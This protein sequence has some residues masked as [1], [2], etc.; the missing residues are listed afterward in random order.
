MKLLKNR[1]EGDTYLI[2]TKRDGRR[3]KFN[4][5]KIVSAIEAAFN[6]VDGE[7]TSESKRKAKEIADYVESLNKTMTVEQIQD[8]IEEKLMAS[9]R[10]DVAKAYILYRNER[11]FIR[12]NTFYKWYKTNIVDKRSEENS[13]ANVDENNF[14]GKEMRISDDILEHNVDIIIKEILGKKTFEDTTK[15]I[16]IHDKSKFTLGVHNCLLIPYRDMIY[17]NGIETRQGDTK[18]TKTYNTACHLIPVAIQS[19]SLDQ[20]GGCGLMNFS[21]YM[22]DALKNTISKFVSELINDRDMDIY[23][24][25]SGISFKQAKDILGN[26]LYKKVRNKVDKDVEN[27]NQALI[28]NLVTLQ[29][30]SGHQLPF[31][32]INLGLI[33]P[34]NE[35]ESA[36]IV[37]MFLKEIDK[38]IGKKDR[39]AVFPISIFQVKSGVNRYQQDKYYYLRMLA[40]EVSHRRLYPT[41]V[42]CDFSHN[43]ANSWESEMNQMGCRTM[44]GYNRFTGTYDREGRGNLFPTTI[45]LPYIALEQGGNIDKFFVRLNEVLEEIHQ[46]SLL[47]YRIICAQSPS[48]APFIKDNHTMIGST[49]CTNNLEPQMKHGTIAYGYIGVAEACKVL[50]GYYHNQSE[51]A[52]EIGLKMIETIKHFADKCSDKDNLNYSV[53]ATPAE[54]YCYKGLEIIKNK[55]G[56]IHGVTDKDYL[57]NSHHCPVSEDIDVFSKIDVES[58]YASLALGGNIFHIEVDG[59]NYNKKAITKAIDYALD[60]DIPYIRI[61]HPIATCL[62]CG[63]AIGKYMMPCEKCGSKNVENL[64]IVTGYLSTDISHMNKGK[65]SEAHDRKLNIEVISNEY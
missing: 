50:V 65:Q 38:G 42:N 40:Q 5:E 14:G 36:Y 61:S 63:F 57:T 11:D 10:K 56:I 19:Q 25:E 22:V 15:C 51:K 47:R 49:E 6:E 37:E 9:K 17:K 34:D 23:R 53:Y 7:I 32:S 21:V 48:V 59:V 52:Q 39:T 58:P 28:T 31:S 27:S 46:I 41:F 45:N 2:I 33:D 26:S 44:L 43:I 16:K 3:Q 64:A 55:F 60:N 4:K 24:P 8:V 18:P 20:F 35:E 13:N 30:R 12:N 62:N 54:G 29:S 1:L